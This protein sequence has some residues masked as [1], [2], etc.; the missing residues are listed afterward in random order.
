MPAPIN[1]LKHRLAAGEVTHGIWLGLAD[2][3]PAEIAATAGFDWLL[4]DGEHAPNDIRSL[5]AQVAVLAGSDS[6]PVIRLPDDDPAKIKQALDIGAQT[7]LIP[8][9]ESAEQATRAAR[10]CRYPP[11]GVRGV[12]SALARASRFAA[13]PDYLA[14]ANAQICLILQVETRAGLAALDEIAATE[15]VDGVFIGPSDLAADMGHLGN[16][17]H[18]EVQAA[19]LGALARIRA[20]GKAAGVLTTDPAFIEA[21]KAA[22]ANFVGVGIDVTILAGALR[23]LAGKFRKA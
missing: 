21:C 18:P 8:M 1:P 6:A 9:I 20:A 11:E 10:A 15:G 12:G 13:I 4:I 3:Y 5:S 22:G 14:T 2:P 7:L 17:G 23:A 16:P 19:V